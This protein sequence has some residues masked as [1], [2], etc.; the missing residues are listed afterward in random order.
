MGQQ[1]KFAETSKLVARVSQY[2]DGEIMV[3]SPLVSCDRK[4]QLFKAQILNKQSDQPV[5]SKSKQR[6]FSNIRIGV[7]YLILY[8]SSA[9]ALDANATEKPEQPGYITRQTK[10]FQDTFCKH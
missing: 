8:E 3:V 1:I 10:F 5:Q 7:V 2:H 6:Q 9:T 4:A